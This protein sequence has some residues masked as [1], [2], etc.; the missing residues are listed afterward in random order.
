M[1]NQPSPTME[2]C[3]A[4]CLT[5][6]LRGGCYSNCREYYFLSCVT[7]CA[8]CKTKLSSGHVNMSNAWGAQPIDQPKALLP[9]VIALGVVRSKKHVVIT[10][11]W[12]CSMGEI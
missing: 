12:Y 2:D 11:L 4:L 5:F 3:S 1:G 6:H 9:Y 10:F 7:S 8:P